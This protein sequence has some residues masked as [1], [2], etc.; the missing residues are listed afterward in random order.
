MQV[1]AQSASEELSAVRLSC[2][3]RAHANFAEQNE[4]V[5]VREV[6]SR[7]KSVDRRPRSGTPKTKLSIARN[8][9]HDSV[10]RDRRLKPVSTDATHLFFPS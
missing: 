5:D 4:R 8:A 9:S 1:L 10:T 2:R 6:K 7:A 3:P